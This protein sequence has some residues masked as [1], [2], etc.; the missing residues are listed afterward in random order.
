MRRSIKKIVLGFCLVSAISAQA[1]PMAFS[2]F[3][4]ISRGM[5]ETEVIDI[6]GMPD[7][8]TDDRVTRYSNSNSNRPSTPPNTKPS[9]NN[10]TQI[11][12]YI[13]TKE[14]VW[15]S[16]GY[17]TYTTTI[18]IRDGRVTDIDRKKKM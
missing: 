6:A 11:D 14:M 4:K 10:R 16:D 2:D 5:K 12:R 13:A 9:N 15:Y 3:I 7:Y 1:A 18:T 8:V 17:D